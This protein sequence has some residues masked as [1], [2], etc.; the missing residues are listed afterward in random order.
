MRRHRARN[1]RRSTRAL[2]APGER[3]RTGSSCYLADAGSSHGINVSWGQ[4]GRHRSTFA[5][6]IAEVIWTL[7]GRTTRPKRSPRPNGAQHSNLP[8]VRRTPTAVAVVGKVAIAS[9]LDE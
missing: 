4:I 6:Y 8:A 9:A 5:S 1:E 7:L 3:S 2:R